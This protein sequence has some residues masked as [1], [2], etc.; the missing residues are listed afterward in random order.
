VWS[1]PRRSHNLCT[2]ACSNR[3]VLAHGPL[4]SP[5]LRRKLI[6]IFDATRNGASSAENRERS[7]IDVYYP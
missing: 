1:G 3:E 7:V 5:G 6:M 4:V 2:E